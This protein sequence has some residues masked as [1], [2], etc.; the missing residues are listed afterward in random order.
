MPTIKEIA[1]QDPEPGEL[2][3]VFANRR[4]RPR[5]YLQI[6]YLDSNGMPVQHITEASGSCVV[7]LERKILKDPKPVGAADYTCVFDIVLHKER[8]CGIVS[9]V[10]ATEEGNPVTKHCYFY[11]KS[12]Y[13]HRVMITQLDLLLTLI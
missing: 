3:M 2:Y 6:Y 8:V 1:I 4:D 9:K 10:Y 12:K 11:L 7:F 5:N 13:D